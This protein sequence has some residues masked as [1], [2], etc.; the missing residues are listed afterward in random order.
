MDEQVSAEQ[1]AAAADGSRPGSGG[2]SSGPVRQRRVVS[3]GGVRGVLVLGGDGWVVS[4]D[5]EVRLV[6]ALRGERGARDRLWAL[7]AALDEG[8]VEPEDLRLLCGRLSAIAALETVEEV[9]RV[10][11]PGCLRAAVAFVCVCVDEE[12]LSRWLG[13]GLAARLDGNLVRG[14]LP[15]PGWESW[16]ASHGLRWRTYGRDVHWISELPGSFW[17]RLRVHRDER[18]RDVAV[19]SDPRARPRALEDLAGCRPLAV[20]VMD[21]VACNPRT[22][23]GLLRGLACR[24]YLMQQTRLR[25]AQNRGAAKRLLGEMSKHR[26][27]EVRYVAAWHPRVPVSA[28]RRLVGDEYPQVRAAVARADTAPE[29]ALETLA[30]DVD[31]WVRRNVASNSSTAQEVLEAL[32]GDRRWEVRAAAVANGGTSPEMAA[33]RVGDRAVGVR[34]EVASRP[35]AAD[36]LAVLAGDRNCRVR[37]AVAWNAQTE[38]DALAVLA[39][40]AC[41]EVRGAAAA[42][43]RTPPGALVVLAGDDDWWVRSCVAANASCPDG[44][45]TALAGDADRYVRAEAAEH[46][47]LS[48]EQ[49]QALAED[50]A[51]EVRAGVALNTRTPEGLLAV[52]AEDGC[53]DVRRCVCE[54]DQAP[55]RLVDALCSDGD[56]WVRAAA[57]AA[58]ERRRA[59]REGTTPPRRTFRRI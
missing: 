40:D 47:P 23:P 22:P 11:V 49:L 16:N 12:L 28:L 41:R 15:G 53:S 14:L 5:S 26:N 35:V 31:V 27:W 24:S 20:E 18:L 29:R 45:R 10:R 19:A 58:N 4:N 34:C 38:P 17:E 54:N 37:Q 43:N 56:Y 7:A 1:V 55:Q 51:W 3:V 8:L 33:V 36:V 9:W 13:Y 39:G 6:E 48:L 21:L 25:V 30:S 52:L 57:A 42:N 32:L 50:D 59:K 2:R 44:A 46:A